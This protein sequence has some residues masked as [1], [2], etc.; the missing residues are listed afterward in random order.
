ME[1]INY[2][3]DKL[4]LT[5]KKKLLKDFQKESFK[6]KVDELDC[7]VS[8]ARQPSSIE[9]TEFSKILSSKSIYII[10]TRQGLMSKKPF[11]ELVVKHPLKSKYI[12]LWIQM[13]LDIFNSKIVTKYKLKA[14][15]Y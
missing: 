3:T 13:D 15:T 9:W 10:G 7:N 8:W 12:F 11:I 1:R 6:V 4:T 2:E 5:L 14:K